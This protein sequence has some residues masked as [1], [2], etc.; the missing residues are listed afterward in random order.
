M[1]P[2]SGTVDGLGDPGTTSNLN[3]F[4]IVVKNKK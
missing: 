4:S 1:N 3:V 2:G